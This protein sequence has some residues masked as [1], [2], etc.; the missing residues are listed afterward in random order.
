M[1]HLTRFLLQ[2]HARI[3]R[4]FDAYGRDPNSLPLALTVCSELDVHTAIEE[5][6]VYPILRDEIDGREADSAEAEHEQ[7]K[8]LVAQIQ[9]LEPGDPQLRDLMA[10]LQQAVSEH[11]DHEEATI[12]PK[13]QSHLLARN[14]DVGRQAFTMRQELMGEGSNRPAA[15]SRR[16]ANAGWS[17]GSIANAGW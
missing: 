6:L 9:G 17:G 13:L 2:D 11:V 1:A 15:A 8:E 3:F 5:E 14:W 7:A 16:V 4:A 12:I 10:N